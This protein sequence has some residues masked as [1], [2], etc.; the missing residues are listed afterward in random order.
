MP[1]AGFDEVVLLTGFPSFGA[2]KMCEEILQ[3]PKTL[4]YAV[5]RQKLA[6]DAM[7]ALDALPLGQRQRVVMFDG[8]AASM[9]LGLSGKEFRSI[10]REIDRIHH[11]AEVSYL[12]T[13]RDA[14]E[15]TNVEGAREIL[16]VAEA[17]TDLKC[18]VFHSTAAVSG[19]RTGLVRVVPVTAR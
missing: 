17:C 4:V 18:L 3:S 16:E 10:T 6:A 13:E 7:L 9:D 2:R 1:R 5:V 11:W 14:A 15:H 19:S 12:G 8:D